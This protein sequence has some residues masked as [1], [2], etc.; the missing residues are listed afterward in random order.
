[1]DDE[2]IIVHNEMFMFPILVLSFL[3][4]PKKKQKT[5]ALDCS[6]TRYFLTSEIQQTRFAQTAL[7]FFRISKNGCPAGT[8][9]GR[10]ELQSS[11]FFF[12]LAF[13]IGVPIETDEVEQL[14]IR[15]I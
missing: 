1:M 8:V 2:F 4:C 10:V 9:K 12:A 6:P 11:D 15:F 3:H 13:V 14:L 5:L 7:D